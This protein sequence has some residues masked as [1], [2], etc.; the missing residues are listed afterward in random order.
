MSS[1]A[2]MGF[3]YSTVI[4]AELI[5]DSSELSKLEKAIREG[6]EIREWDVYQLMS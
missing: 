1:V 2:L 6:K 3:D 4:R 5:S